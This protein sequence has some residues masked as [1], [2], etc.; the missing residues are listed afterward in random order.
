MARL[1]NAAN[2]LDYNKAHVWVRVPLWKPHTIFT[3]PRS[4]LKRGFATASVVEVEY[5]PASAFFDGMHFTAD[6]EIISV[7]ERKLETPG[8][9]A[10]SLDSEGSGE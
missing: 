6:M 2:I 10:G 7:I 8:G 3:M 1:R 5:D 4:W 9:S